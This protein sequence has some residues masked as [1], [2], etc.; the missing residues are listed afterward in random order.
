MI[1]WR[2]PLVERLWIYRTIWFGGADGTRGLFERSSQPRCGRSG[3]GQEPDLT[4]R[5]LEQWICEGLGLVTT[6]RS[7]RRFFK[8]HGIS[9]KKTISDSVR[10]WA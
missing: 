4:L 8:R 9:F 10:L 6:E 1:G 7:I 3:A 2:I 5:E